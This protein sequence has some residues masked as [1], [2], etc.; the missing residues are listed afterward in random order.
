MAEFIHYRELFD[1][2]WPFQLMDLDFKPVHFFVL[3]LNQER[4]QNDAVSQLP[5]SACD[6]ISEFAANSV[7]LGLL[8]VRVV[9]IFHDS[10]YISTE[11]F[12]VVNGF[13]LIFWIA[14]NNTMQLAK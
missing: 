2:Y 1:R 8:L 4:S 7:C 12:D 6:F 5:H 9:L 3:F 13:C 10:S 14:Y 11:L